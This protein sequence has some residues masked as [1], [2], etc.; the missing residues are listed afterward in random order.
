MSDMYVCTYVCLWGVGW[1]AGQCKEAEV[2]WQAWQQAGTFTGQ[3]A[4][5]ARFLTF[6]NS[7]FLYHH[8]HQKPSAPPKTTKII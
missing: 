5:L 8:H 7:K 2:K 4:S 1:G 3:A 6:L